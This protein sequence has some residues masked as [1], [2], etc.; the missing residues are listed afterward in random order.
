MAPLQRE[1]IRA[2]EAGKDMWSDVGIKGLHCLPCRAV[3]GGGR[4]P[5]VEAGRI[6]SH[7]QKQRGVTQ[8]DRSTA[9]MLLEHTQSRSAQAYL[10]M[11]QVGAEGYLVSEMILRRL[12]AS[13]HP[14]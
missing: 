9:W 1:A 10:P 8:T 5:Q 13:I 4:E 3:R 2:F 7:R 11:A 14:E 12:P 6:G